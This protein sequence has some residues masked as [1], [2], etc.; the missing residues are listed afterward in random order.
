[1]LHRISTRVGG[2]AQAQELI[3]ELQRLGVP[4]QGIQIKG[5]QVRFPEP[6]AETASGSTAEAGDTR[7]CSTCVVGLGVIGAVFGGTV[8]W[9][10]LVWSP[11]P[12]VGALGGAALCGLA[13]ARLCG[14]VVIV[15]SPRAPVLPQVEVEISDPALALRIRRHLHDHADM[16]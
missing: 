6:V 13:C 2:T 16:R 5:I 9:L 1:M 11:L 15:S 7:V 4:D 10:L 12:W 3:A 14:N 8:G